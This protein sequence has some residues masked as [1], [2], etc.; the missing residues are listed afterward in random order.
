[1]QPST[2]AHRHGGRDATHASRCGFRCS[3][4][5][6]SRAAPRHPVVE[7]SRH[8]APPRAGRFQETHGLW[9]AL[10][11]AEGVSPAAR[12][13]RPSPTRCST[14]SSRASDRN[15]T[16]FPNLQRPFSH[17]PARCAQRH[18]RRL[19]PIVPG[20][21]RQRSTL[22]PA[23]GTMRPATVLARAHRF[24]E[25]EP[26]SAASLITRDAAE[27]DS[28]SAKRWSEHAASRAGRTLR[29]LLRAAPLDGRTRAGAPDGRAYSL[30]C[31]SPNAAIRARRGRLDLAR[32]RTEGRGDRISSSRSRP[33]SRAIHHALAVLARRCRCLPR[34]GRLE[35]RTASIAAGVSD[36]FAWLAG[37][38][39]RGAARDGPPRSCA[40]ACASCMVPLRGPLTAKADS[41]ST[42]TAICSSGS[43]R[44]WG[45]RHFLLSLPIL[46]RRPTLSPR[47]RARRARD[48]SAASYREQV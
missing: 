24:L 19:P 33:Q 16:S 7:P 13:G 40:S 41:P 14:T 5:S 43:A 32:V 11:P 6:C 12:G 8:R 27:L 31:T 28:Q 44:A 26:C 37:P 10:C 38:L 2:R 45:W 35:R 22:D 9:A 25:P 39:G 42:Y 34:R 47:V 48:S 21:D 20:A 17:K 3:P 36:H 15:N 23:F 18:A 30:R 1:M 4:C 46:R 29:S